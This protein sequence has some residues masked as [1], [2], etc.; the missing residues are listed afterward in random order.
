MNVKLNLPAVVVTTT[1]S[2]VV[3]SPAF[4]VAET[5]VFFSVTIG[6]AFPVLGA[7]VVLTTVVTLDVCGAEEIGNQNLHKSSYDI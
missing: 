4:V 6:S 5:V 3:V 1:F 2:R 7:T